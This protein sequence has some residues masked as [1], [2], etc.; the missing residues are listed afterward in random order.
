MATDQKI[1]ISSTFEDMHPE[2]DY[3]SH[4]TFPAIAAK[5]QAQHI[6]LQLLPLDLRVGVTIPDADQWAKTVIQVCF[7]GLQQARPLLLVLLGERYGSSPPAEL[8][9]YVTQEYSE[10][11]PDQVIAKSVTALEIEYGA[12]AGVTPLVRFYFR[13]G[14]DG[15]QVPAVFQETEPQN[16]QRQLALKQ[17]IQ[18]IFPDRVR[19]YRLHWDAATS[20]MQGLEELS[21]QIISDVWQLL[22]ENNLLMQQ[23]SQTPLALANQALTAFV[24]H[25]RRGFQGRTEILAQLHAHLNNQQPPSI[26]ALTGPGGSGKSAVFAELYQQLHTANQ[27]IVLAH[28]AGANVGIGNAEAILRMWLLQLYQVLGTVPPNNLE[29]LDINALRPAFQQA[30]TQATQTQRVVLLLDALDQAP[31]DVQRLDWLPQPW[32][33]GLRMIVTVLAGRAE[34]GLKVHNAN[35]LSLPPLDQSHAQ[36][37]FIQ[38]FQRYGRYMDGVPQSII[39][40]I[41]AH[42]ETAWG[43]PLWLSLAGE[44]LNQITGAQLAQIKAQ[45]QPG[46]TVGTAIVQALTRRAQGFAPTV[47]ALFAEHLQALEQEH[48]FELTAAYAGCIACSRTGLRDED[49]LSCVPKLLNREVNLLE[50]TALRHGFRG[51]LVPREAGQWDFF[52]RQ[53]R[54][55]VIARYVPS[56]ETKGQQVHRILGQHLIALPGTDPLQPAWPLHIALGRDNRSLI[57][58]LQ[59]IN[60]KDREAIAPFLLEAL[61]LTI[62][63]SDLIKW[64]I[65]CFDNTPPTAIEDLIWGLLYFQRLLKQQLY[66]VAIRQQLLLGIKQ[67]IQPWYEQQP[68]V[69]DVSRTYGVLLSELGDLYREDL[70]DPAQ[71]QECYAQYLKITAELHQRYPEDAGLA[72]DY[73]IALSR[74]GELYRE[75]LKDPARAQEYY[76]Q[77]LKITAELH[78]RYPE[79]AGLAQDYG[80]ALSPMGKLYREDLKDPAQAQECYAQYLKITAELHQ[81]Y[82]EDARLALGYGIALERMGDLYREDL[83]DPAQ[84]QECYAQYLKI[85]AELHQRY[86]EDADLARDYGVALARMVDLYRQDLKDPAR[87]QEYYA[88]VLKIFFAELHQRYPEDAGLARD[89]G[90]ALERMGDLYR[91]DLKDPARAQECYAPM[92]KIYADLHQRYPE[93][94]EL[95]QDYGVALSRMGEL[96]REDLKDPARAQEYYAQDL[97]ISAELH[98]RYPE[99]A[100]LAQ[101]YGIALGLMGNLYREDLQDPARA[102]EYYAQKLKINADLHQR[103]PE[104]ADLA[105]IYGIDLERM[106]ELYREDLKDPARAQE[107]YAQ[108]L[109]ISAEL[110]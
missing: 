67:A 78:Q 54:E 1:F 33:Q 4:R 71:A 64:L 15:A 2:R 66:S 46:Q 96:Y 29:S 87:A 35:W 25:R 59:G 53:L 108:D 20:K 7:D 103:Y 19:H 97:E 27:H 83:K 36:T 57:E 70:K 12:F 82:P 81:R 94:A 65:G 21:Q 39:D 77:Y 85:T 30:T 75:D 106:G 101:S 68:Q 14:I 51:Q 84:A 44:A 95:A 69:R 10:L 73:G 41:L 63:P 80:I 91:Q 11:T 99:D 74:M 92:L 79:D 100:G 38:I 88:Q 13:D 18:D 60:D 9:T 17:R 52:H 34:D 5:L 58:G 6:P 23:T 86:P 98:Q 32:P 47:P 107:Y 72:R 24:A 93:D 16:Y 49:L 22:A 37:A 102:Q 109:E 50:I 48:G 26:L 3:L 40:A 90:I 42:G 61:Q 31:T 110:H 45:L 105:Q 55:G 76:A 56:A 43:N 89:Y 62:P 104:D 28:A 8:V